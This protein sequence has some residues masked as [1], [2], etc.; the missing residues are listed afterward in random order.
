MAGFHDPESGDNIPGF[1]F[2]QCLQYQLLAERGIDFLIAVEA[3]GGFRMFTKISHM[4]Q[5]KS[6]YN[7]KLRGRAEGCILQA[8]TALL[9]FVIA[10]TFAAPS[11]A[12]LSGTASDKA[13]VTIS[14][15]G[16]GTKAQAAPHKWD[17]FETG[18]TGSALTGWYISSTLG[19][20]Y[21]PSYSTTRVRVPGRKS[22]YQNFTDG[23]YNSAMALTDQSPGFRTIYIS[24]WFYRE[25][26]GASSRNVKMWGLRGGPGFSE[27]APNIRMDQYPNQGAGQITSLEAPSGACNS[28]D[29]A[30]TIIQNDW[31]LSQDL[32]PNAWH[33]FEVW[34]DTDSAGSNGEYTVWVDGVALASLK[35]KIVAHDCPFPMVMLQNYFAT[36]TGSPTPWM[37]H[38]WD[39]V[40]IDR[41]RARIEIGNASTW[42]ASSHREIQIPTAWSNN[43]ISFK[44]NQGSFSVGDKGYLYVIDATGVPSVGFPITIGSGGGTPPPSELPTPTN[45][46]I[47]N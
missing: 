28:P 3:A 46:R 36:D 31:G 9:M 24:G 39:E 47:I 21:V 16:F 14:G 6:V 29:S 27:Y 35:G 32:F 2:G 18:T 13:S 41:T 42:T 17:D 12:Q 22:A 38:Y 10:P 33:R 43:S 15:S 1:G 40:Y 19:A 44:V 23:N 34:V 30:S 5:T 37:R 8:T 26:G 25:V 20:N 4:H 7:T 11:I 45:L